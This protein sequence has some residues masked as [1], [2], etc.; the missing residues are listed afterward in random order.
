MKVIFGAYDGHDTINGVN[1]WLRRLLPRL[2]ARGLD[3]ET[4]LI[5]W[6]APERCSTIPGLQAA[7]IECQVAPLPYYT[8]RHVRWI[9]QVLAATSADIFVPGN[10]LPGF[11]ASRWLSDAGIPS[12]GIAHNDDRQ[13]RGILDEFVWKDSPYRL[14]GLVCV[15]EVL[16]TRARQ[17]ATSGTQIA[18]I[19]CG[20]SVPNAR[21]APPAPTLRLAYAGRLVQE[22]KRILDVVAAC[23]RAARELPGV[24]AK[25]YGSG[26]EKE[27]VEKWLQQQ[28]KALPVTLVGR[29]DSERMPAELLQ[30][31]VLV[32]LSD[33]EGLPVALMEAMACGVVPICLR[34]DSGIPELVEDGVTGL[35]VGDRGDDFVAAVRRLQANPE[36][37]QKLSQA[38]RAKIAG[39]YS[40]E[41]SADRW[42]EFL[43]A[44]ADTS[45]DRSPIAIPRRLR[46]PPPNPDLEL[47][48]LRE[49]AV[50]TKA[51]RRSRM[52]GGRLKRYLLPRK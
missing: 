21:A 35:L 52:L 46:L 43:H 16:A 40:I 27:A 1:A 7:G 38:A 12:V 37:W 8:D 2:R 49:P 14:S 33:Y 6:A 42:A 51:W 23:C 15:S 18:R 36:L 3:V 11:Y 26:P 47:P 32:L 29:V 10:M 9:L 22:Q 19:P 45:G 44:L 13:S 5:T 4:L 39:H 48:H 41:R 50:Y 25:I 24:E 20:V 31:H 34:I 30:C 28:G 17:Q